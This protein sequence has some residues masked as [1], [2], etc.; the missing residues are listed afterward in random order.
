VVTDEWG[1]KREILHGGYEKFE[2]VP[3][4]MT[5]WQSSVRMARIL[6]MFHDSYASMTARVVFLRAD[7]VEEAMASDVEA[8]VRSK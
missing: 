3:G 2:I 6:S 8:L 5:C 1:A 4:P 7:I